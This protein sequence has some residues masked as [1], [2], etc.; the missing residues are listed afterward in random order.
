MWEIIKALLNG[1][2]WILI[3]KAFHYNRIGNVLRT[4]VA[5]CESFCSNLK[6]TVCI[7]F[8]NVY[9]EWQC[10]SWF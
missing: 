3:I 10:R 7:I 2:Q 1:S 9:K 6:A 5:A 4:H 8:D